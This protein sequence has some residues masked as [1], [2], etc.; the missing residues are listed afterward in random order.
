MQCSTPGILPQD[1]N[2]TCTEKNGRLKPIWDPLG[3]W[4]SE[5]CLWLMLLILPMTTLSAVTS[6]L[7]QTVLVLLGVL[8]SLIGLAALSSAIPPC[9]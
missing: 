7:G 4:Q 5:V 8:L 2:H 1:H 6:G 3:D 9:R